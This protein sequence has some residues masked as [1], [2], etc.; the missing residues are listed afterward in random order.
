MSSQE[1]S[2]EEALERIEQIVETLENEQVP[3]ERSIAYYKEGLQLSAACQQ[4]LA[5]AEGEIMLLMETVSGQFEE[6]PF[7]AGEDE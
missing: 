7:L 2:F 6:T 1:P 5:Q 4:K 3:L